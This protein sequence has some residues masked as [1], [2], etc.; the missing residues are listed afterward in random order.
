MT[1]DYLSSLNK[2]GSGLNLNEIVTGLVDAEI[3]PKTNIIDRSLASTESSISAL[4]RLRTRYEDLKGALETF[5]QTEFISVASSDSAV[6]LSLD[7]PNKVVEGIA[8]IKVNALAERQVVEFGGFAARDTS[9]GS[10]T[11]TL[12]FGSWS[13]GQT[14][15]FTANADQQAR[16]LTI[17]QAATLDDLAAILGEVSGVSARVLD[18]GD[19]T[20]SL[21]IAT[22]VGATSAIRLTAANA[23]N[24]VAFDMTNNIADVQIAGARNAELQV[25]GISVSRA[26]NDISDLIGGVTLSLHATTTGFAKVAIAKDDALARETISNLVEQLNGM[27]QL[28]NEETAVASGGA[29]A[30]ALAGD[31]TITA[32]RHQLAQVTTTPLKGHGPNEIYLSQLGVRTERNGSL[33]L[34]A[35]AFNDVFA[36]D[37]SILSA[38]FSD[39]FL[40][41]NPN[42]EVSGQRRPTTESGSYSFVVDPDTG[43]ARLGGKEI[44]SAILDDGR[45]EY[46][47]TTGATAGITLTMQPDQSEATVGFGQSL[48]SMLFE[49]VETILSTSGGLARREDKLGETLVL[50]ATSLKELETQSEKL[51]TRYRAKFSAMERAV[52][53]LNATG[54]FLTNLVDSWNNSD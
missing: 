32:L 14:M 52:S 29:K 9:I 35:D 53:Q 19:G 54:S 39:S 8:N 24:L 16:S 38:V 46:A 11:L 15:D 17:P 18:K 6:S 12:E 48:V 28:L 13:E 37:P 30:G 45:I 34:D 42:V 27:T 22:D 31:R 25:D 21:G 7:D 49:Q 36:R 2:S 44:A 26:T 3:I 23:S 5:N 4:G 40:S 50:T 1:V 41:D 10:G 33:T 51:E 43:I 47:S 20:F